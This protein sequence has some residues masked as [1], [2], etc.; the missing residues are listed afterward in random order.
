MFECV[1]MTKLLPHTMWSKNIYEPG[2]R[3]MSLAIELIRGK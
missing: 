2:S 3:K 1:E